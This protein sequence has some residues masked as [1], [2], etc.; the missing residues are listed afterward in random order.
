MLDWFTGLVTWKSYTLDDLIDGG[1]IPTP[2]AGDYDLGNI[3]YK[4][5]ESVGI[6]LS[7]TELLIKL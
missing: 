4:N 1:I 3:A 6:A 5:E 2:A 7:A